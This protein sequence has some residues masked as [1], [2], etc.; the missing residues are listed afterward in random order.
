MF[1]QTHPVTRYL[2]GRRPLSL[3]QNHTVRR[4]YLT[5]LLFTFF[6]PGFRFPVVT[7]SAV[8]FGQ[9]FRS[10]FFFLKLLLVDLL[11]FLFL[12][13]FAGRLSMTF[14][15][16]LLVFY[17]II[18]CQYIFQIKNMFAI[19]AVNFL[20]YNNCFFRAPMH[21]A[22]AVMRPNT[23]GTI[24][25]MQGGKKWFNT[26]NNQV[27]GLKKAGSFTLLSPP[28]FFKIIPLPLRR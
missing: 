6:A 21:P 14:L 11:F 28:L 2:E 10:P 19:R 12:V 22:R 18:P 1:H 20:R 4:I 8:A 17:L 9:K 16:L 23:I 13:Y 27:A 3:L 15:V 26:A 7:F 5:Q 25:V 24:A